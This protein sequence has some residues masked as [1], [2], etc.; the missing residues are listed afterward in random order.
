MRPTHGIIDAI[1]DTKDLMLAAQGKVRSQTY[2][3]VPNGIHDYSTWHQVF[4]QFLTWAAG[5]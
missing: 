4:P 5:L 3:E 1:D 2:V